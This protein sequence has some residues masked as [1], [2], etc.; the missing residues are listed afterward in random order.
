MT[1][2]R[3]MVNRYGQVKTF[4]YDPMD[5]SGRPVCTLEWPH[6]GV[7]EHGPTGQRWFNGVRFPDREGPWKP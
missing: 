1:G 2:P 6:I 4:C 7:H 3:E 5:A